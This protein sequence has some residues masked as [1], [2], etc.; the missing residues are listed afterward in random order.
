MILID[1]IYHVWYTCRK[2]AGVPAGKKATEKIPSF[3]WD[4]CDIWHA[5]SRDGW[6]WVEDPVPAVTRLEKPNYG[7]R[8]IST[9][10]ILIW[11]DKYYL[12]YQDLTKS[13]DYIR[14]TEPPLLLQ[15]QILHLVHGNR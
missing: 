10:D 14:E 12:Y 7:W 8:S 11:E 6:N 2:T 9:T 15:S 1:G 4:L 13:Q 3:D 5:T